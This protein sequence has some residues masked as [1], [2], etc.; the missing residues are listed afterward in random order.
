MHSVH[1]SIYP[2][3]EP[4]EQT[5]AWENKNGLK[6]LSCSCEVMNLCMHTQYHA[7]QGKGIGIYEEVEDDDDEDVPDIWADTYDNN[8]YCVMSDTFHVDMRTLRVVGR[9]GG[10]RRGWNCT[11]EHEGY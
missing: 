2:R 1:R 9:D 10:V 5:D 4:W 11:I 6:R 3:V 7:F 8:N